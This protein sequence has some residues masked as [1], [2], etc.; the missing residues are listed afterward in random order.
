MLQ[1]SMNPNYRGIAFLLS[2]GSLPLACSKDKDDTDSNTG[3]G[4]GT[5]TGTMGNTGTGTDATDSTPT[6]S[7]TTGNTGTTGT[8]GT[9]GTTGGTTG[10]VNT[11][12]TD[13]QT[14][15]TTDTNT[16]GDTDLPPPTD[17]T[18]IAYA[19]HF[20]EC[21]PRYAMY[22]E[23][24][25]QYC[26]YYKSYGFQVDGQACVNALEAYFVC[27]SAVDCAEIENETACAKESSAVENDCPNLDENVETSGGTSD[28]SG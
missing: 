27:L 6:T 16:D 28:S 11:S 3:T 2:L 20:V 12:G 4:T 7:G 18:C 22:Q 13:T 14:S 8:T 10:P 17:P 5:G 21:N 15:A 25:A 19:A 9:S 1:I 23:S 26:E 24:F